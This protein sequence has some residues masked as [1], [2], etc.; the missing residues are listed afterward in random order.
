[1]HVTI[2]SMSLSNDSR[3][4]RNCVFLMHVHLVF[5]TKYRRCVFTK[6]ILEELRK[7]F[8]DV[9]ND[10]SAELAE[11]EGERDHVHSSWIIHPRFLC[12]C[13][14]TVW[15]ESLHDWSGKTDIQLFNKLYGETV[16]GRLVILLEHVAAPPENHPAIYWTA[17]VPFYL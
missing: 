7:I 12:P 16:F 1:M 11:F 15:R 14:W 13:L 5:I 9:C 10:F 2:W 17:R 4:G 6:P 3:K 8:Q